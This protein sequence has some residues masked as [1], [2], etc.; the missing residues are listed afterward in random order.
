MNLVIDCGNTNI[1]LA[2]F[3]K[4]KM[5][6]YHSTRNFSK[7]SILDFVANKR[8][9]RVKN[10]C[11]SNNSRQDIDILKN[12]LFK[13]ATWII[14]NYHS[15][16]PIDIKYHTP[17]KLGSDRIALATGASIKY[18]GDKLIIDFGT[19]ITYDFVEG[20]NYF[21]GQI[22]LGFNTRFRALS[23]YTNSLPSINLDQINEL[24]NIS[25]HTTALN[26]I[27]SMLL[28]IRD[29]LVSELEYVIQKYKS[30]YPNIIIVLT[31]GD[32]VYLKDILQLNLTS[33]KN[34]ID[35][36]LLMEGLN[37]IIAFN[38]KK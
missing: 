9:S 5:I 28:G 27:D 17:E 16:L 38:E 30:R 31:G 22:S 6:D 15:K 10:V 32:M 13:D 33:Y 37:Y 3:F 8:P 7:K 23:H 21:G 36:Y 11:V 20:T 14:L 1:K 2:L 18:P 35:S 4:N 19:C 25:D 24:N 29:S 26:T 12:H 34:F